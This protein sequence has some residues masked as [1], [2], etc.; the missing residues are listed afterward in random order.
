MGW[1]YTG[2]A[3]GTARCLATGAT[4]RAYIATFAGRRWT[5]P[6]SPLMLCCGRR[7]DDSPIRRLG[8]RRVGILTIYYLYAMSRLPRHLH[9][10]NAHSPAHSLPTRTR[11]HTAPPHAPH[12]TSVA[13]HTT[14]RR[15]RLC[16][17]P[18]RG[19]RGRRGCVRLI[20]LFY[21]RPRLLPAISIITSARTAAWRCDGAGCRHCA[22]QNGRTVFSG[23]LIYH[24]CVRDKR[25]A[26]VLPLPPA[27]LIAYRWTD[28]IAIAVP[29]IAIPIHS[30][31]APLLKRLALGD[32]LTSLQ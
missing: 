16:Y 18:T 30:C 13:P 15:L 29:K 8:T 32:V 2:R 9:L 6:S 26:R 3:F 27:A 24:T 28:R 4:G 25:I 22:S 7:S 19:G 12:T 11:C 21:Y 10:T 17:L 23:S 14:A 5:V 20:R 31:D 1:A